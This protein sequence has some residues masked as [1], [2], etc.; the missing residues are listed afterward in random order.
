MAMRDWIWDG[1][2]ASVDLVNTLRDRK[3]GAR[4]LLDEADAL[5]E[6][7]RLAELADVTA[8]QALPYL[9]A[10]RELRETIDRVLRGQ[11]DE[12]DVD[13]LN[14]WAARHHQPP[15]QLRLTPRR[16]PVAHVPAPEEPV[17]SA[18]GAAAADAIKL[19]LEP[20]AIRICASD[21]CGLR[22]VD[23]SPARNRQ[24]CSMAR[25]GNRAKARQHYARHKTT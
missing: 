5:A 9:R 3:T 8:A 6:W 15:L 16:E 23:R 20:S 22:F 19:L 25:C 4:E 13:A 1:G 2:R 11:L 24:W 14:A 7:L 18:L 12:A 21:T 17:A 10:A